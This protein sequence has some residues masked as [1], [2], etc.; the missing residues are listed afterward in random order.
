MHPKGCALK[1]AFGG[2]GTPLMDVWEQ[3]VASNCCVKLLH[4]TVVSNCCIKLLHPW[5][6]AKSKA[7]RLKVSTSVVHSYQRSKVVQ[8]Y[9]RSK[10]VHSYQ[11][12]KVVHSYQL[13]AAGLL[14][15]CYA[16]V[17]GRQMQAVY[18]GCVRM[19]WDT[20]GC[21]QIRWDAFGCI[22]MR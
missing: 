18:M 9:Q 21:I 14:A 17:W 6:S 5:V 4:Q 13:G 19:R 16:Y 10:V 15:Y 3:I 7:Q 22:R 11:C 12:S 2:P 1:A 20:L 8:S